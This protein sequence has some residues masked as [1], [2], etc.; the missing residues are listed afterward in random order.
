MYEYEAVMNG[1]T[2]QHPMICVTVSELVLAPIK[3]L[4]HRIWHGMM[5][6]KTVYST[7]ENR[8]QKTSVPQLPLTSNLQ[9]QCTCVYILDIYEAAGIGR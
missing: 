4:Y 9:L 7:P 5:V 2:Y 8:V 6:L 3:F 1:M